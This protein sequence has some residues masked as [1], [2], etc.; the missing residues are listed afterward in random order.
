GFSSFSLTCKAGTDVL[1][2]GCPRRPGDASVLQAPADDLYCFVQ[3]LW[4]SGLPAMPGL[5]TCWSAMRGVR[6]P[7]EQASTAAEDPVRRP[8]ARR[9]ANRDLY[10][11]RAQCPGVRAAVGH[12]RTHEPACSGTC[13]GGL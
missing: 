11:H 9:G 12:S 5:G 13:T 8:A 2:T 3:P 1:R 10:V 7:S 4:T 6:R